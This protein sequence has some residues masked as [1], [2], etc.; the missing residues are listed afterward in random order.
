MD[1]KTL[2]GFA[3]TTVENNSGK[4]AGDYILNADSNG[5]LGKGEGNN[6]LSVRKF[7]T[8]GGEEILKESAGGSSYEG[9]VKN[10]SLLSAIRSVLNYF[11]LDNSDFTDSEVESIAHEMNPLYSLQDVTAIFFKNIGGE[12]KTFFCDDLFN[13]ISLALYKLKMLFYKTTGNLTET[14]VVKDPYSYQF[15][16]G[17]T[18]IDDIAT[19]AGNFWGCSVSEAKEHLKGIGDNLANIVF[20]NWGKSY[21]AYDYTVIPGEEYVTINPDAPHSGNLYYTGYFGADLWKSKL[22]ATDRSNGVRYWKNSEST[23]DGMLMYVTALGSGTISSEVMTKLFDTKDMAGQYISL[24]FQGEPATEKKTKKDAVLPSQE[25]ALNKYPWKETVNGKTASPVADDYTNVDQAGVKEGS[26]FSV[27]SS[28]ARDFIS[29]VGHAARALYLARE[30]WTLPSLCIAQ[31]ALESGWN[32]NSRTM[33]G[34]KGPGWSCTTKEYIDGVYKTVTDNFVTNNGVEAN[35]RYYYDFLLSNS[36]YSNLINNSDASD[37]CDKV[38]QDGYATDPD[39]SAKLKSII[40]AYSLTD[41]DSRTGDD[42]TVTYSPGQA[43]VIRYAGNVA[44][45]SSNDPLTSLGVSQSTRREIANQS[46]TPISSSTGMAAGNVSSKPAA[47][48]TVTEYLPDGVESHLL[49]QYILTSKQLAEFGT[50]LWTDD[51]FTNLKKIFYDPIQAVISLQKIYIPGLPSEK[52]TV[53]MGKQSTEIEAKKVTDRYTSYNFGSVKIGLI[54]HN[55]LDFSGTSVYIYLPW[56]GFKELDAGLVMGKY[57]Q[58]IYNVDL[59]T[60]MCVANVLVHE[61]SE[62]VGESLGNSPTYS[63]AG[64]CT[65]EIPITGT[66]YTRMASALFSLGTSAA[67][68]AVNPGAAIPGMIN[69]A[70]NLAQS[71]PAILSTGSLTGNAGALAP[72]TPYVLTVSHPEYGT[73]QFGLPEWQGTPGTGYCVAQTVNIPSGGMSSSELSELETIMKAGFYMPE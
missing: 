43:E 22:G 13:N 36:R 49:T 41:W 31:G 29:Q 44:S 1:L 61:S 64:K 20:M 56:I 32:V 21:H 46:V 11:G 69:S 25:L 26:T 66:D 47:Y 59:L 45:S 16:R 70:A 60:G 42:P 9:V 27:V 39:Y 10:I 38:Y 57:I 65:E 5:V 50:W 7:Q 48:D 30:N 8:D 72:R 52:A 14:E 18:T 40:S 62:T 55:A 67:T 6:G 37:C 35:V 17:S 2:N 58:L 33:F 23:D 28:N 3:G 71:G 34:I 12:L 51:V 73:S 63:F 15:R 68:A 4:S 54:H 53:K 24:G 19:I